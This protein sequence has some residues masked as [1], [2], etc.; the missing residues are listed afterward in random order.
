VEVEVEQ[1]QQLQLQ[2]LV[3]LKMLLLDL[4]VDEYYEAFLHTTNDDHQP[5]L[6]IDMISNNI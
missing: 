6:L 1:Q 5:M 3:L 2:L 4:V